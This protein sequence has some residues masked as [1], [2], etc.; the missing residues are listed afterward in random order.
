MEIC[1]CVTPVRRQALALGDCGPWLTA[2]ARRLGFSRTHCQV[3]V[4]PWRSVSLSLV[5]GACSFRR[6]LALDTPSH[7]ELAA[8]PPINKTGFHRRP[9]YEL[10]FHQLKSIFSSG[11]LFK[12][13]FGGSIFTSVPALTT[14]LFGTGDVPIGSEMRT[15]PATSHPRGCYHGQRGGILNVNSLNL[16][17]EGSYAHARFADTVSKHH[18]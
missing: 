2:I 10:R 13:T 16:L 12:S 17:R 18:R 3:D 6:S 1:N 14:I 9:K 11:A 5:Q 15:A 8:H 4:F 7:N